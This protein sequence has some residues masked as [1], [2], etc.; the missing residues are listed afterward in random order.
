MVSKLPDGLYPGLCPGCHAIVPVPLEKRG[1]LEW[2]GAC[3][4]KFLDGLLK[5]FAKGLGW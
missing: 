2:C 3:R 1:K 4:E 5:A